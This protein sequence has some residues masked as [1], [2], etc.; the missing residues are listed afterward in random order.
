VL[1]N[2][3]PLDTK[4]L[5]KIIAKG[6]QAG[7]KSDSFYFSF[8]AEIEQMMSD[9]GVSKEKNIGADGITYLLN[10]RNTKLS[11]NEFSYWLEISP[12]NL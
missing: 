9:S 2:D 3:K 6:I 7:E 1:K 5:K 8:P 12:G 10:K 11:E 4:F